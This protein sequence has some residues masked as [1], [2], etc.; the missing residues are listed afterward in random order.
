MITLS[1][2][3]DN[4]SNSYLLDKMLTTKYPLGVILM[5][6][7]HQM[8]RRRLVLRAQWLP[9]LQNDEADQLT[10]MDFRHFDKKKRIPVDLDRLGFQVL[11]ELFEAG[12]AYLESLSQLKADSKA[13]GVER[14]KKRLRGDRGLKETD[15]W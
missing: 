5:E 8:R 14:G 11:P 6:L 3:T 1:C 15:P 7:A 13:E 2:G 12:E 9:R 4:Q 10:N